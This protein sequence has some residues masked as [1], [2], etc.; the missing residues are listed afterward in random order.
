M[1]IRQSL[2]S[3]AL[4]VS[5]CAISAARAEYALPPGMTGVADLGAIDCGTF[6]AMYPNG[7]TGMSQAVLAWAQGYIYA[8]SGQTL[9]EVIAGLPADN[10]WDFFSLSSFVVEFCAQQPDAPLPD[11]V[12]ALWARLRP[13]PKGS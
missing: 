2:I 4:I 13:V 5:L 8:E 9:D 7:P 1:V 3:V 10:A 6:N 11:A 12:A